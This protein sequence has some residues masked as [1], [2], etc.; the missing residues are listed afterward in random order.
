MS[1]RFFGFSSIFPGS[2]SKI[3]P[4]FFFG[5]LYVRIFGNT[6]G[7]DDGITFSAI[8]LVFSEFLSDLP[9]TAELFFGNFPS[10]GLHVTLLKCRARLA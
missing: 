4:T 8:S 3:G 6:G 2:F 9:S 10:N 5:R 7:G 1:F